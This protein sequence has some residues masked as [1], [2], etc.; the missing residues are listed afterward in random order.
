MVKATSGARLVVSLVFG[1]WAGLAAGADWSNWRGP[2]RTG[3][4]PEQNLPVRWSMTENLAWTLPLPSGG[5]STSIVSGDRVFLNVADGDTVFLWCVDRR[6]GSVSWKQPVGSAEGHAHRKHNM[7]TPSPVVG[8]GRVFVMTG[9]GALKGF[10]LEGRELWARSLEKDYGPFGTNWGYGSSPLLEGGTLYV[11]VLHGMKTDDPSYLL[12]LDPASGTTRFRVERPTAARWESPDAYTTP[13]VARRDGKTEIIVTGGDAVTGHDPSTGTE[14]WRDS[15]LNPNNEGNY[16]LVAS[17]VAVDDIVV[18]PSRVK[19]MVV[20]RAFGR[21][22]VTATHRLWTFDRGPDVPTPTTDGT[23]LYVVTDKGILWCLDLRTG[24]NVYGPQRLAVGTYSSSPLLADGKL[25]VTS[26]DGLT[27]VI[28]A[29]PTFELL[30]ENALEG[31]TLSSPAAAH[32]Q[33]FL[34]TGEAL[35]CIG[36]GG[37]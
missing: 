1:S 24:K 25:Y 7:A 22:D 37:S 2:E 29:G 15:G 9:N 30:A 18:V 14:L 6:T 36:T 23:L 12:G 3:T 8:D 26:E 33:L 20:L 35:Y 13:V 19:P 31:F 17:A 32:G 27:S 11:Q 28:K 21:G 34:R 4:S 10:T 16:R 5:G